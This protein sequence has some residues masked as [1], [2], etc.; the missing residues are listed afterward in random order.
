V[1]LVDGGSMMVGMDIHL[2]IGCKFVEWFV[3][4]LVCFDVE[5][6]DVNG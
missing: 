3:L 4:V 6:I 2:C 5:D 1:L